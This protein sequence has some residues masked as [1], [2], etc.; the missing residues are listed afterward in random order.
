MDYSDQIKILPLLPLDTIE[1]E[2]ERASINGMS[3]V[4]ALRPRQEARG[5]RQKFTITAFQVLS[6]SNTL[7]G[8]AI[9]V[10]DEATEGI[11]PSI[12]LEIETARALHQQRLGRKFRCT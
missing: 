6:M 8:S 9:L 4:I 12:I 1:R 10:L 3:S 11:Q 7:M 5:K 2:C